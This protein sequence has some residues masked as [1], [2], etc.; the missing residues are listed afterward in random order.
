MPREWVA[1]QAAVQATDLA[2]G[3]HDIQQPARCLAG[4]QAIHHRGL[5]GGIT[6]A[7]ER[8]NDRV[9]LGA[10]KDIG[11]RTIGRGQRN[12]VKVPNAGIIGDC[13]QGQPIGRG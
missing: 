1:P 11:A 7:R 8:R 5:T 13:Q 6:T 9:W 4:S 10:P 2:P 3:K 12:H